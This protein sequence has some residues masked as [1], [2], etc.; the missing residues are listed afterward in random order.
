MTLFD[1]PNNNYYQ[2]N[3]K[4]NNFYEHNN[5]NFTSNQEIINLRNELNNKNQIIEQQKKTINDLQNKL[6]NLNMLNNNNQTLIKNLQNDINNKEQELLCLKNELNKI[7]LNNNI[8]NNM[9]DKRDTF[10]IKFMSLPQDKILSIT[11]SNTDSIAKCEEIFYNKYPEYKDINT[12]LTANGNAIKR[13]KTIEE[14]KIKQDNAIIVNT[15]EE[16]II[17]NNK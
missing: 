4:L 13:F 11:C 16:S 5:N 15:L 2:P 7:N 12:Y 8:K 14:N 9:N 1:K 17:N 3:Q 10:T 6:S